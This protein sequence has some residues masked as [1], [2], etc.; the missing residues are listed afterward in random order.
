M[1]DFGF[2]HF[3]KRKEFGKKWLLFHEL[4]Y[5]II[6]AL[7]PENLVQTAGYDIKQKRIKSAQKGVS[8]GLRKRIFENAL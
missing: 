4:L 2:T 5:K 6:L 7:R 1:A 8:N 3:T